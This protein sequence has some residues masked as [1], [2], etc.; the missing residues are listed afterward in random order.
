MS[1]GAGVRPRCAEAQRRAPASIRLLAGNPIKRLEQAVILAG[2]MGPST[3][4]G[5]AQLA[6]DTS[7]LSKRLA[8]VSVMHSTLGE[9]YDCTACGACC[10]GKR[11]YVQVFADDVARLGTARTAEL[12]A[13]AV[14]EIP[15]SVGRESEAQRFMKMTHGHC[16]A[17]RTTVPN[18][19]LCAVYEDR[20]MLCRALEPGSA[21]CLEARAR[22]GVH[23]PAASHDS[24]SA[25]ES[26]IETRSGP[27]GS[28]HS[29][30]GR[31]RT[32]LARPGD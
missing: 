11:D 6:P 19:F 1:G 21:P 25:E 18:R 31:L 29:A 32:S 8:L 30:S 3:P 9:K 26:F 23:S 15:A 10:F 27:H 28:I 24:Q 7:Q 17:L 16:G 2:P 22:R 5:G 20:P 13:P 12:V 14:G 4:A